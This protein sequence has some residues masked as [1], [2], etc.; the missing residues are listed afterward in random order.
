MSKQ[1]LGMVWAICCIASV[2][3]MLVVQS[4]T[5]WG[6]A[7]I[8]PIVGVLVAFVISFVSSKDE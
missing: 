2:L 1:R 7:W 3:V 5:G 8:I 4:T 6:L